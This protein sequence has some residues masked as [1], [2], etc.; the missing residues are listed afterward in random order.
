MS[1]CRAIGGWLPVS[2]WPYNHAVIVRKLI[3][4]EAVVAMVDAN[5][6]ESN[7]PVKVSL[8]STR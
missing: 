3:D 7:I 5:C 6:R 1:W 8:C 2:G 4:E